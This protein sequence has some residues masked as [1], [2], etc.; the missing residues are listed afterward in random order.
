MAGWKL[1]VDLGQSKVFKIAKRVAKEEGFHV[2]EVDDYHFEAKRGSLPLS[3]I[4][5][6]LV[7]YCDF[8]IEVE[9]YDDATDL[10]LTRNTPW[11]TGVLGVSRVKN[12]AKHLVDEIAKEVEEE[13]GAILDKQE[14]K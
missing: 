6:A 7:A 5:G 12:W 4:A 1:E 14:V 11:W 3:I 13:E 9:A 8:K 2:V 10:V